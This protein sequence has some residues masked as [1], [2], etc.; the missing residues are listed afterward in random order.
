MIRTAE[1]AKE[2]ERWQVPDSWTWASLGEVAD[3]V[4]GGTPPTNER[5]NYEGGDI[6]WVTPADLS[7]YRDKLIG[8]GARNITERGLQRSGARLLPTGTVLFSSRAPIGYVAIA[9]N[10]VSTN[11]GFKSFVLTSGLSPDYVYYYLQRAK[12]IAVSL[13]S[14]TTFLEISGARAVQIPMPIAPLPEQQ[15]IVA[16][17]EQQFTR[18]DAAVAALE[19]VRANLKRYRAAVLKAACEGRLVPTE[20]ELARAEGREYEPAQALLAR[21]QADTVSSPFP[22][23]KAGNGQAGLRSVRGNQRVSQAPGTSELSE[24]PEGW[25]WTTLGPVLAEPLTNGHSVP[26]AEFGF[27]VLRLT[28]LKDGTIDLNERKNGA[29]SERAATPFLVR[30]GDFL[31]ARGNGSLGLVG[32]GGLVVDLPDPVAYP[33]TLIRVRLKPCSMLKRYL[34]LVWNSGLMRRQVEGTARTTAGIY[35][36]NQQDIL[37]F[38]LPL[39]PLGEQ[40]RIVA[41][42]ERRLSVV[43]AVEKTVEVGLKRAARLR[44]A[45]LRRAFEGKLVPQ[46]PTDEP[47]SALLER[48]RAERAATPASKSRRRAARSTDHSAQPTQPFLF[49][50]SADDKY[51]KIA[52]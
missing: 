28:A 10:P 6:P 41:E 8:R 12:D 26:S 49:K 23:R 21:V 17:I 24:L 45:I 35:K 2:T 3:V 29:W 9:A 20:A 31:V 47:A 38:A 22:D 52:T 14:G 7:G 43:E 44:Q 51:N 25:C 48:I 16:E 42:V 34:R 32:R 37:T 18:L 27:P 50:S 30:A 36:I 40:E 11:Q 13:A 5:A 15:R 1:G 46:D 33:D 4:G 39:P 19:R